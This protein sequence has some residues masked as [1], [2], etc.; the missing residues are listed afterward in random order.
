MFDF[1]EGAAGTGKTHNLIEQAK[2]L[3]ASGII[4]L[5]QKILALTFMNG[6]RRRLEARLNNESVFSRRY[7]CMTFDVFARK[8]VSRR[9]SLIYNTN[10]L[11]KEA[12]RLNE[13]DKPCFL[14]ANLLEVE[15]VQQWVSMSFPLI[16]VDEAQDLDNYRLRILKGLAQ[17]S[18]VIAAAY[19]G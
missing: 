5:E 13:F 17:N 15:S 19:F 8:L 6:S 1:F 14:A 12:S 11:I 3:L 16:I 2:K 7:E 9:S 10:V 18:H 4:E